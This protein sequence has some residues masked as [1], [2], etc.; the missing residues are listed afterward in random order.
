MAGGL[1]LAHLCAF[2]CRLWLLAMLMPRLMIM[3]A[4]GGSIIP[5]GLV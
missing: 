1:R 5:G 2:F 3:A 4:V